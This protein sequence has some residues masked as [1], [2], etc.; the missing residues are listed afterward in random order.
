MD[1]IKQ[2]DLR[3]LIVT[4][5]LSMGISVLYMTYPLMMPF[6]SVSVNKVCFGTFQSN[7]RDVI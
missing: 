5:T 7:C 6:L 4:V 3:P 1:I 2:L